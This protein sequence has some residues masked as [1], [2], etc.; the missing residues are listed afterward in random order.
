[1][2]SICALHWAFFFLFF[3][4][5][6]PSALTHLYS[7]LHVIFI[8]CKSTINGLAGDNLWRNLKEPLCCELTLRYNGKLKAARRRQNS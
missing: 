4:I 3:F 5:L 6:L 2:L 1:M 7:K 8:L